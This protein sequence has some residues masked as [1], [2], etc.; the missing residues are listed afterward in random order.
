MPIHQKCLPWFIGL[1]CEWMRHA[2]STAPSAKP[3]ELDFARSKSRDRSPRRPN[4]LGIR[5]IRTPVQ[6][7]R[8]M[9]CQDCETYSL[10]FT[11]PKAYAADYCGN[12]TLKEASHDSECSGSARA[13]AP[14]ML[15]SAFEQ[16]CRCSRSP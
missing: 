10:F 3:T 8:I 14:S 9:A 16:R 1:T 13:I 11:C 7:A 2:P 4:P 12:Q 6:T 5:R 15:A